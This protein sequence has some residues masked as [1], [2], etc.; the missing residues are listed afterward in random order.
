MKKRI[1]ALLLAVITIGMV[2]VGC[3][4]DYYKYD[5]YLDYIQLGEAKDVV[6][7][8]S[9]ID[10]SIKDSYE[11]LFDEDDNIKETEITDG[12][13]Q[14]GDT[15]TIDYVGKLDGVAFEGGT[16]NDQ[17]LEIGSNTYI[18][19]FE[20]GLIGY[21]KG[22]KVTLNLTFPE[23]YGKEELNG[24]AVVFEVTIDKVTRM[25]YPEYNDEN[26]KKYSEGL[27][28]TVKAFED[29]VKEDNIKNLVW[30]DYY[31][32]C[33][34]KKYP[35][36]EL[37]DYYENSVE[38]YKSQ[39][40][41][42]G[43]KFSTYI[44][45]YS[46]Y[47]T[48]ADFYNA[49]AQRA[50]AQVKQDLMILAAVESIDGLKYDDKKLSDEFKKLYDEAITAKTFDGSFKK[51]KKTYGESALKVQVYSE[52][53]M[54]YLMTNKTVKDDVTKNGIVKDSSGVRFYENGLIK[55]GWIEYDADG[56]GTTELYYFDTLTDYAPV[57]KV[58]LAYPKGVLAG[59]ANAEKK[60]Y[61]FGE[62]GLFVRECDK[63]IANDGTGFLYIEQ[64]KALSGLVEYEHNSD[65]DGKE[66]YY[67]DPNNNNYMALGL[68]LLDG[69]E[70]GEH[71]G[72][73]YNFGQSGIYNPDKAIDLSA[74]DPSNGWQPDGFAVDSKDGTTVTMLFKDSIMQTG[75]VEYSYTETNDGVEETIT[76]EYYF[77]PETGY[78]LTDAFFDLNNATYYCG[79]DGTITKDEIFMTP[80]GGKYYATETGEILKNEFHTSGTDR[81]YATETGKFAVDTTIEISGTSYTFDADGKQT[82]PALS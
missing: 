2:F 23:N 45:S 79:S 66:T 57:N 43:M 44:T 72:K 67:F 10:A 62:N 31:E 1:I 15:V 50:Q 46:G 36:K 8:Q 34:V 55:N 64:G 61:Y 58:A 16:A 70:F 82:S 56:N 14:K 39:A 19:G 12:A 51:F 80:D 25:G 47:S 3:S 42:F 71:E 4:G 40:A 7:L 11:E 74:K 6:I 13:I 41:M 73:H 53:L 35:K 54:D 52:V 75:K 18:D 49:Q 65:V 21:K 38:T 81:Y 26:V 32:L 20:D 60:Y 76:N 37:T 22:D 30:N 9:D 5:S 24:K 27:Y 29:A 28:E 63:E 48:L 77:D 78:M 17:K 59:D 68:V 33:K 69:D